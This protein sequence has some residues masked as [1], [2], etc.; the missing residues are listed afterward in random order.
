[1]CHCTEKDKCNQELKVSGTMI[2]YPTL[3]CACD[4]VFHE[5]LKLAAMHMQAETDQ[6]GGVCHGGKCQTRMP[7][8]KNNLYPACVTFSSGAE[9]FRACA[10]IDVSLNVL[11]R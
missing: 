8:E 9:T 7:D 3:E 4:T 2:N 5:K 10:L 1:M 11:I 6:S